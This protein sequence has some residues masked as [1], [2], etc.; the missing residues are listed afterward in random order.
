MARSKAE[1]DA[2]QRLASQVSTGMRQV[3]D[4]Y[5]GQTAN[6][7]NADIAD[8][9]QSLVREVMHTPIADLRKFDEAVFL[10]DEGSYR[11]FVAYEIRKRDMLK[12]MKKQAQLNEKISDLTRKRMEA[13]ID[14][15][16]EEYEDD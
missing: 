11:V 16:L 2:R 13:I 9:F 8:K 3:A 10:K 6:M 1:L 5:L 14:K 4:Q 7:E 15:E 12:F